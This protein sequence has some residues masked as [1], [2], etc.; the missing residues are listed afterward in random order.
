MIVLDKGEWLT[1]AEAAD[2]LG[3]SEPRVRQLL[4][5]GRLEGLKH[6]NAWAIRKKELVR[7]SKL[8][9]PVGNPNFGK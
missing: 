3:L 7:F 5:S 1:V 2:Y 4:L 6:A 9:R 8:D